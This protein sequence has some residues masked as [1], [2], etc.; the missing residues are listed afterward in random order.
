MIVNHVNYKETHMKILFVVLFL[1]ISFDAAA[2]DELLKKGNCMGCHNM[3]VKL[4]GPSF[5]DI[6]AKY[7]NKPDAVDYLTHKIM[8]GGKGVWGQIPMPAKGGNPSLT[9]A[10]L[11][12]LAQWVMKVK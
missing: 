12:Q 8:H 5:K 7:A 6:Q 4:V 11:K 2:S 10:E 1:L 9:D 3:T